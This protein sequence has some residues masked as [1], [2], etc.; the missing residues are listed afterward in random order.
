MFR[1]FDALPID[2]D[3]CARST[4]RPE[5]IFMVAWP[6][7]AIIFTLVIMIDEFLAPP[8][9]L[10]PPLIKLGITLADL[11]FIM[12]NVANLT[13]AFTLVSRGGWACVG[14]SKCEG[15]LRGCTLLKTL[16]GFLLL[17]ALTWNLT[18]SVTL[19]RLISIVSGFS[20]DAEE[21][22]ADLRERAKLG[23]RRPKA[24]RQLV[25]EP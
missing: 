2:G 10:R 21:L 1:L 11:V 5:I 20:S 22:V 6:T 9:G 12:L 14:D 7:I 19:V 15:S 16:C 17:G 24:N 3:E 23:R 8:I 18:F 25:T 4:D 13:I